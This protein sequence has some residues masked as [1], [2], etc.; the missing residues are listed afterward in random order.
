MSGPQAASLQEHPQIDIAL[1]TLLSFA[2]LATPRARRRSH[3]DNT[4]AA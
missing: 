4:E 2:G 3:R 1:H